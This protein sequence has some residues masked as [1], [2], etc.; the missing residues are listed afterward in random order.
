MQ[1]RSLTVIVLMLISLEVI[2]QNS[3]YLG[4]NLYPNYSSRRLIALSNISI[5]EIDSIETR[6]TSRPSWSAGV[7]MGWRSQK[8]GFQ[9]GLDYMDSGYRTVKEDLPEDDP[10]S[11]TAGK[12]RIIFQGQYLSVPMEVHF[13]QQLSERSDFYFMMGAAASYNIGN[14][15]NTRYYAGEN[16]ELVRMAEE[17]SEYRGVNM[18]FQ[19][20]LGWAYD[21][22][23]NL[24]LSLQPTFMFWMRG[25]LKENDLNRNLYSMGLRLG[26]MF[27]KTAEY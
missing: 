5:P 12:R 15:F 25:V 26:L 22:S 27:Q 17:N 2:A 18:A 20:G 7:A 10:R 9:I 1:I 4:L 21:L 3:F 16:D 23:D 11:G 19:S 24:R 13:Y 6:E 14:S 8:L